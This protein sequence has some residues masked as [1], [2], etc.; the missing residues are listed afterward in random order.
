VQVNRPADR[1]PFAWR[2][3]LGAVVALLRR[4]LGWR[5]AARP[6]MVLPGRDQPLVVVFN[7]T[8]N[9]DAFLVA[10][11]I[12]RRLRHWSQPLVKQELFDLP[13]LG[14][15]VRGAGAIPVER[16][17]GA[18]R[19]AA[20]GAAVERLRSGGTVLLA[21]EGTITHDGSLLPLR[22]G[23]ARMALG[24]G[25][26]VLVVTHFGAQRAFSPVVRTAERDV[27]VTMAFDLLTPWPDEDAG[28]LTGRIAATL[29]DRS[30]QLR[31]S[32]PQAAPEARWWPPYA[33]P[34]S[35]SATARDSLERYRTSMAEAVTQ[36][37]GRM[38]AF[39]T[40]HDVEQ[41]VAAARARADEF[42]DEAR[43]RIDD[44]A[45]LTRDRA[46]ELAQ[47]TRS[48]TDELTEDARH[49]LD[50]LTERT[51]ARA[52][53]IT[54]DARQ[55]LEELSEDARRRYDELVRPDRSG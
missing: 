23:A 3:A 22:H 16:G 41:R 21:P 15:L 34:A 37:R 6:P 24:A 8:S 5:V 30:E 42:T 33:R 25:V 19:E 55:R 7:H 29:I 17:Q 40:E 18:G 13:L 26:D 11:T 45:E 20:Y 4:L 52:D 51:R 50:E 39:A 36:A 47:R 53:E 1:P 31:A 46:E 43:H 12:W 35:P 38:A 44:F 10:D 2:V 54:D 14:R 48:R 32:Y 28:G 9:I 27:V 49:R